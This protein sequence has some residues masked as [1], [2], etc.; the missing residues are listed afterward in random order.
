MNRY[1]TCALLILG[2]L[3]AGQQPA[4]A[5]VGEAAAIFLQ[6]EPDSRAAAMGNANV[7]MA[8]N[9]NAVFWNPAGLARQRGLSASL[10]HSQ[11][12]PQFNAGLFYDYLVGKYHV[13]NLG[14]FGGHVTYFNLGEH[15]QRS[16]SNDLLNTFNAYELAIGTSFGTQ[17]SEHFDVGGGMRLIY[18][19]LTGGGDVTVGAQETHAGVSAGFDLAGMYRSGSFQLGDVDSE[20]RI[21][22]NLANMGPQIQYSDRE[23][24]DPIPTNMRFGWAWEFQFDE[25]NSL[26]IAND[27]NKMLVESDSA[28]AK[29]WYQAVFSAWGPTTVDL[30]TTD[31]DPGRRLNTFQQMTIATGLEYWYNDRFAIRSGY[32]Y[33]HPYYGNREFLTFGAGLRYSILGVD[34]SYIYALEENHP[35]SDTIRFSLLIDT[36][37]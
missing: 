8:D 36:N 18:S 10:T 26:T 16:A 25:Y 22:A 13:D 5:Q 34:F 20:L 6:I 24:S 32:F 9:A 30:N 23:Q 29:P 7:A 12:L 15:E 4:E 3:V 35:L 28:G 37:R 2:L 33:E 27:F 17:V 11:W 21:G 31:D 19:S 14:T 1:L